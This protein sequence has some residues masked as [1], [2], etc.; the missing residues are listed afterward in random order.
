[1]RPDFDWKKPWDEGTDAVMDVPVGA[2]NQILY[3]TPRK[4]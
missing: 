1:M 2:V 3:G 4:H